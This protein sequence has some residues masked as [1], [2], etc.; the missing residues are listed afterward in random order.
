MEID[1]DYLAG[2]FMFNWLLCYKALD[3]LLK[4]IYFY[5]FEIFARVMLT[6]ID[7]FPLS[8]LFS[9]IIP[10]SLLNATRW[11]ISLKEYFF[12]MFVVDRLARI[13]TLLS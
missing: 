12:F 11:L 3:I 1:G 13:N 6:V 7:S 2:R 8:H 4:N 9:L 5:K 10:C